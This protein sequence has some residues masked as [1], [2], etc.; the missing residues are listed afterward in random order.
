MTDSKR[1]DSRSSTYRLGRA[2]LVA[3]VVYAI[4][5]A[6]VPTL[7]LN[8]SAGSAALFCA[9][10]AFGLVLTSGKRR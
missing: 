6:I 2:V 3:V 8:V 1:D 5:G 9:V 7:D 4:I 10:L